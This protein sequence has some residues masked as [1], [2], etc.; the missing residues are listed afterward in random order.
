MFTLS[1][2]QQYSSVPVISVS[3]SLV[4][5]QISIIKI[6]G[7][8]ET[9][10]LMSDIVRKAIVVNNGYEYGESTGNALIDHAYTDLYMFYMPT[11]L[12]EEID[13][14]NH[15]QVLIEVLSYELS[16]LDSDSVLKVLTNRK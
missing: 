13:Y 16:N 7:K 3:Q 12:N 6:N 4:N 10:Q 14:W 9:A 11:G 5:P 1:I 15:D 2:L 8:I